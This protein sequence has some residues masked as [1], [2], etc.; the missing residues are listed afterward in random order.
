MSS[1][2]AVHTVAS[3]GFIS[4]DLKPSPL[5]SVHCTQLQW[6]VAAPGGLLSAVARVFARRP[7]LSPRST[8]F[9][10]AAL[11]GPA[12]GGRAFWRLPRGRRL[13]AWPAS[14]QMALKPMRLMLSAR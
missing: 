3:Q 6:M 1:A 2:T 5:L 12:P 14:A 4:L 13:Q 10:D 8:A 11:C 9:E 7:P